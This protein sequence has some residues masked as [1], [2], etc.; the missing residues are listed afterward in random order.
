MIYLL[1][2]L[3]LNTV[4]FT[5]A[6]YV[7]IKM[8]QLKTNIKYNLCLSNI[9]PFLLWAFLVNCYR[10]MVFNRRFSNCLP[11]ESSS[12]ASHSSFPVFNANSSS[13][14]SCSPTRSFSWRIHKVLVCI[15][16]ARPSNLF[17]VPSVD[18]SSWKFPSCWW[19]SFRALILT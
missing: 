10:F 9:C 14:L 4:G 17:L 8:L 16:A 5:L 6:N 13:C 12:E 19:F 2:F 1:A 11:E 18:H 7:V 3:V 15:S